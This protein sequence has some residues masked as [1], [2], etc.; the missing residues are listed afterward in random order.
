MVYG[1]GTPKH[2]AADGVMAML[3]LLAAE[4][5]ELVRESSI[6]ALSFQDGLPL[7]FSW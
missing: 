5:K 1:I 3:V 7:C 2:V 6:Y 4:L